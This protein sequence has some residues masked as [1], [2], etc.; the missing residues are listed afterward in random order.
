VSEVKYKASLDERFDT[1]NPRLNQQYVKNWIEES[2]LTKEKLIDELYHKTRGL[3][4]QRNL[5]IS[6]KT[7]LNFFGCKDSELSQYF[8]TLFADGDKI[9]IRKCMLA[10]S[11]LLFASMEDLLRFQFELMDHSKSSYLTDNDLIILLQA[12]HFVSNPNEILSKAKTILDNSIKQMQDDALSEEEFYK[13]AN[14]TPNLL[15]LTPIK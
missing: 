1:S 9:D 13:L 4:L 6:Y 5:M 12:N 3:G 14:E 11:S 15:F 2:G 7:M 8:F 10:L